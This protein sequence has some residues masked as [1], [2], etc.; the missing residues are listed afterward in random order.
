VRVL[1]TGGAGFVGSH[2][3]AW[4]L[5][6]RHEVVVLDD[7]SN[8]LRNAVGAAEL[9]EG[10]VRDAATVA[11]AMSGVEV[12]FHLAAVVGVRRTL[13]MP[14]ETITTSTVGTYN[15]LRAS[16]RIQADCIVFSS[17]SMYGKNGAVPLAE[18]ADVVL[19]NTHR[20]SWTYSYAKAAE[21]VLCQT[22]FQER[23][24]RV[25]IVRL[26]NVVGPGQ[27][28]R[29]GMVL[30]RF[31]AAALRREPLVVY[32]DGRQT[33]TFMDIE[34]ALDGIGRIWR[35]G[36]WGSAYNVGGT[37]EVRIIDLAH[38]VV[39]RLQSPSEVEM[40]PFSE[41][42]DRDYEETMRRRPD[43]A[44]L[45]ALGYRPRHTLDEMIDR[46]ATDIGERGEQ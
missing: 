7:L 40:L 19:G 24:Q 46:V 4:L 22:A 26:F 27:G 2:L 25:K 34:D 10:D 32:G 3:V 16:S 33:R 41:A 21:E 44:R 45:F 23:A 39:G 1:V 36:E 18:E 14:W 38:R 6:D 31:V 30:P 15:V 43:L 28:E 20:L 17:S 8:G 42:F 29:Y 11:R 37:E 12:V 9:I 35:Q 13:R 5:Q